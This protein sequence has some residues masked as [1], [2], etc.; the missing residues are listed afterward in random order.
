MIWKV[1]EWDLENG[2]VGPSLWWAGVL[3]AVKPMDLKKPKRFFCFVFFLNKCYWSFTGNRTLD[4]EPW[5]GV[6]IEDGSQWKEKIWPQHLCF[7]SFFEHVV[8]TCCFLCLEI[9]CL[10]QPT[11]LIPQISF[12][13]LALGPLCVITFWKHLAPLHHNISRNPILN[14]SHPD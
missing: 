13:Y 4:S 11:S 8:D 6:Q 5:R 3:Y 10:V 7:F 12:R 2:S 14:N 1:T 9:L